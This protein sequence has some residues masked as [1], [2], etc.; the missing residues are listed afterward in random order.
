MPKLVKPKVIEYKR[1][2][3]ITNLD[4]LPRGLG[5]RYM[6]AF[7]NG[8]KVYIAAK[9]LRKVPA[10]GVPSGFVVLHFTGG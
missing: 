2:F 9:W 3:T 5:A 10:K 6:L 1:D 8:K 4:A 7:D